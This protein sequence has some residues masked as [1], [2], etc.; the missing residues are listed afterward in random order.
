MYTIGDCSQDTH[1]MGHWGLTPCGVGADFS[2]RYGY[3]DVRLTLR[4][5]DKSVFRSTDTIVRKTDD[6]NSSSG[7]RDL[8]LKVRPDPWQE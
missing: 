6:D 5:T 8:P 2:G 7:E 3:S 4:R 1:G